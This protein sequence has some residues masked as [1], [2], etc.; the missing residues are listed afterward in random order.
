MLPP[1]IRSRLEGRINLQR[2]IVERG[3]TAEPVIQQYLN[4]VQPMHLEFVEPSKRYADIIIPEGGHNEV[5][6]GMVVA[7]ISELL[8]SKP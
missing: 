2:D 7:R 8:E 4:T 5:A 3:R 6:L 1:F